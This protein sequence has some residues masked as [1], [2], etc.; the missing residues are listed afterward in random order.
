MFLGDLAEHVW[1]DFVS[2]HVLRFA[3]VAEYVANSNVEA[4]KKYLQEAARIKLKLIMRFDGG[5]P[6]SESYVSMLSYK[7]LF[8]ALASGDFVLAISRAG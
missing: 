6:I 2:G 4:F 1:F 8:N 5:E 3:G 7:S